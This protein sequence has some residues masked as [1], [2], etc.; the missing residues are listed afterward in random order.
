MHPMRTMLTI[1]DDVH[2]PR[3]KTWRA[4]GN[5]A[6][7]N[8]LR[9]RTP[10][11]APPRHRVNAMESR[12]S[13]SAT[14]GPLSLWK[15]ST[16]C[17]MTDRLTFALFGQARRRPICVPPRSSAA[18]GTLR[19]RGQHTEH[20]HFLRGLIRTALRGRPAES[21]TSIVILITTCVLLGSVAVRAQPY[22]GLDQPGS[23]AR[24]NMN[25]PAF[26]F[27]HFESLPKARRLPEAQAEVERLFPSG[28][29]AGQF[30]SY[31]KASGAKCARGTD[32]AWGPFLTCI[33]SIQGLSLVAT[34]WTVS[35]QL[36]SADSKVELI[37][38]TRY[39]TGP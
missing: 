23:A 17:A 16:R 21:A 28:S 20:G 7:R 24:I 9:A 39:L 11:A 15:L 4:P 26:D 3:P 27:L 19:F 36:D 6:R 30:E 14:T 31:F 13:R 18:P 35:A 12:C 22:P 2:S 10:R 38:V 33:Y 34:N 29:D 5:D 25:A 32:R 1:D 8:R 37:T